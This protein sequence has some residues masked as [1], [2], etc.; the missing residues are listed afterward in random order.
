MVP[1]PF[2]EAAPIPL[3]THPNVPKTF[4]RQ[5][6]LLCSASSFS[7]TTPFPSLPPPQPSGIFYPSTLGG[8]GTPY[9]R[10]T[11]LEVEGQKILSN[12]KTRT[13]CLLPTVAL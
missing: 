1:K 7:H 9:L 5:L 8:S 4:F 10:I 2:L 13:P 6:N 12:E 3:N 11:G